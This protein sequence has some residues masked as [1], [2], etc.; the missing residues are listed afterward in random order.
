MRAALF[1]LPILRVSGGL[2]GAGFRFL[3]WRRRLAR[4]ALLGGDLRQP[5]L[6][7]PGQIASDAAFLASPGKGR[8]APGTPRA[9]HR[10]SLWGTCATAARWWHWRCWRARVW[11]FGHGLCWIR[12]EI[13]PSPFLPTCRGEWRDLIGI[14]DGGAHED[15]PIFRDGPRMKVP[16]TAGRHAGVSGAGVRPPRAAP[17]A[18]AAARHRFCG[19][20][21]GEP[22][23]QNCPKWKPSGAG[24]SRC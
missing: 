22:P 1:D 10:H 11:I 8:A 4:E 9:C 12:A 24:W 5:G 13:V 3:A 21:E 7:A 17:L 16:K 6:F 23:C 18:R 2:A 19:P 15:V 20:S 14:L